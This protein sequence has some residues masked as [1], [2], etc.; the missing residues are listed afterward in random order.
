MWYRVGL[1]FEDKD[2]RDR[3]MIGQELDEMCRELPKF[4][5]SIG[6]QVHVSGNNIVEVNFENELKYNPESAEG[7]A[8]SL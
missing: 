6:Q 5:Q 4:T 3:R 2:L 7:I 1:E 8:K